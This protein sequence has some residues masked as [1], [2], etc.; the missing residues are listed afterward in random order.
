MMGMN[1]GDRIKGSWS[2]QEDANLIKLVEEHGPRNWS[3]ISSGIPGRSGKS[4]RLR[5]C[6]QLSPSV[7]HRPF[8]P[9]EDAIIVQAHAIHGNKWAAIA[10]LLPGRTDNAIKNHWNSTL[11]RRRIAE[12]S[13]A[14][15]ESNSM[16]KR[17][18]L[19]VS[20][21]SESDEGVKRQCLRTSEE[22]NSYGGD[23]GMDEPET[24]LTLMPPGES[25]AALPAGHKVEEGIPVK[26]E[27]RITRDE[28]DRCTVEMEETCLVKVMQRMIAEE[29]KGIY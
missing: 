16:M 7:Q 29:I 22:H 28:E 11:R 9:A 1:G 26:G 6:N 4:C 27:A 10:R 14:S 20:P 12:L 3:L 5:W 15:S 8:T 21:E 24:L 25:L 13:S 19:D 2:P 17:L 18:S 23:E